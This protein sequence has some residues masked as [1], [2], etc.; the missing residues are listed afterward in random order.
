MPA[1]TVVRRTDG[2][3]ID[4][5]G[6]N[7]NV[8]GFQQLSVLIFVVF[9]SGGQQSPAVHRIPRD[10]REITFLSDTDTTHICRQKFQDVLLI[11]HSWNRIFFTQSYHWRYSRRV[12]VPWTSGK[13]RGVRRHTFSSIFVRHKL[14]W[15]R[16]RE[17]QDKTRSV[18]VYV[19]IQS[20]HTSTRR[21]FAYHYRETLQLRNH[22][23]SLW[24]PF[25]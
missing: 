16:I 1:R 8:S 11:L 7:Y 21:Q 23:L 13:W 5:T 25:H 2:R 18:V 15:R 19:S 12:V 24:L 4:F 6:Y 20:L 10:T 22:P 3:R 17:S 14:T 9:L